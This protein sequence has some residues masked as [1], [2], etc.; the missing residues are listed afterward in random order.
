VSAG[1]GIEFGDEGFGAG[2]VGGV[3]YDLDRSV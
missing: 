1:D 2:F 3:V